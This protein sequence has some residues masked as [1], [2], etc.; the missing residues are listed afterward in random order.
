M[1]GAVGPSSANRCFER[2]T[3]IALSC[4]GGTGG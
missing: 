1:T 4:G 3:F 2:A